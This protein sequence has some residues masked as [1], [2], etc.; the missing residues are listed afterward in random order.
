MIG[1]SQVAEQAVCFRCSGNLGD[2]VVTHYWQR[3]KAALLWDDA[4]NG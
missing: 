4:E 1:K 3:S 2:V